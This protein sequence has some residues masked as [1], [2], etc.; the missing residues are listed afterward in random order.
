MSDSRLRDS[1]EALLSVATHDGVIVSG[2]IETGR[3]VV[4]VDSYRE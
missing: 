2:L 3:F 1:P 4:I